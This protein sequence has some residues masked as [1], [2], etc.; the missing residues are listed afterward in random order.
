M[1]A[2]V[3]SGEPYT[4]TG[5]RGASITALSSDLTRTKLSPVHPPRTV[6]THTPAAPINNLGMPLRITKPDPPATPPRHRFQELPYPHVCQTCTG[7]VPARIQCG[8]GGL[9][10]AFGS[11]TMRFVATLSTLLVTA[12]TASAQSR[13]GQADPQ[14]GPQGIP[15]AM[16]GPMPGLGGV[17][18]A[19]PGLMPG[20]GGVPAAIPQTQ[21]LGQP[22]SQPQYRPMQVRPWSDLQS[23][24]TTPASTT[25]PGS[26]GLLNLPGF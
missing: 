19:M 7:L 18:A 10:V 9:L 2:V 23:A 1:S 20:L 26:G 14:R 8:V 16:P 4:A 15:A 21:P 6:R 22:L 12:A 25:N 11:L 17:P 3:V 24:P 5:S 13:S